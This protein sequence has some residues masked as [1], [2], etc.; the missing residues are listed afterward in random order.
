LLCPAASSKPD[1]LKAHP[2]FRPVKRQSRKFRIILR[3]KIRATAS[4]QVSDAEA[5]LVPKI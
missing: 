1:F 4:C 5:S 3:A 2:R